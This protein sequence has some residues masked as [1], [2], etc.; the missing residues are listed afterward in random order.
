MK[1]QGKW[2]R[3]GTGKELLRINIFVAIGP[4]ICEK[5]YIV[6]DYVINFVENTLVDVEKKP[7]NL[8]VMVNIH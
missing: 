2:L 1:L 6:N 5:C 3:H 8:L 7:Y 4:S